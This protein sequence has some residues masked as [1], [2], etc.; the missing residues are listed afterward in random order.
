[1]TKP[2]QQSYEGDEQRINWLLR[3][4]TVQR[5]Y[6]TKIVAAL[7]QAQYDAGQVA[8]NLDG[9]NI[10]ERARKYQARL[11]QHEIRD[12][13]KSMFKDLVPTLNKGQQDAAE[14]AAKA[15]LAQDA[16]VLRELFPDSKRRKS[17]Q[18][19]YVL[20]ARHG[21]G[22]MIT[23]ILHTERPLSYRV[24]HS[25]AIASGSLDRKINSALA[26]GLGAKD[27]AKL[28]RSDINPNVP[29]GVSYAAMRLGRSEINNAF[30]AQSIG[31]AQDDPWVQEME[32][33]L[34]KVHAENPGDLCEEYADEQ[35]FQKGDVP[36]K[37]H[38][39]CM[40]YVT[41]KAMQYSDFQQKLESGAFDDY[42]ERKYGMPAA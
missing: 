31:D 24:Y 23:R 38:P 40:C 22:A 5:L 20:Q 4:I 25:A 26:R 8:D 42:F 2:L 3:Y 35:Y 29:G 21:I 30:H 39:Q 14:A 16:Q 37:P 6:D 34:S 33:H 11:V 28:V 1:L 9:A 13:I 17:F 15:A 12:I 19:S 27:I 36:P 32:W 10:S 18:A 7:Q 41:R